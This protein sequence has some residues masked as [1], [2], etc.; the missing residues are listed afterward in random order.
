MNIQGL[1]AYIKWEAEIYKA[2]N[3]VP[4]SDMS[5]TDP[6]LTVCELLR[7]IYAN[8]DD[9]HIKFLCRTATSLAKLTYDRVAKHEGRNW[10]KGIWTTNPNYNKRSVHNVRS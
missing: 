4:E 7:Q 8:T 2:Y 1:A 6:R 5:G 10:G 9:E 3:P